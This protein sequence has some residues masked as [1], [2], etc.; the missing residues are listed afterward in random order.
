VIANGI[1]YVADEQPQAVA[2]LIASH[3]VQHSEVH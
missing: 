1:H 2:D 3:A